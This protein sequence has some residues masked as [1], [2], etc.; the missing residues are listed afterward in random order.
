MR[1]SRFLMKLRYWYHVKMAELYMAL[2]QADM[3][4]YHCMKVL[5]CLEGLGM[6][7]L[8]RAVKKEESH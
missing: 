2:N 7:A 5:G 6:G 4:R 3:M 1:V 8:E